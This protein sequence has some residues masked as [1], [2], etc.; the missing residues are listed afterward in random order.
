MSGVK[1][2]R[3]R[4]VVENTGS[5]VLNVEINLSMTN[6]G[7]NAFRCIARTVGRRWMETWNR[8]AEV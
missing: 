3:R 6:G 1:V 2:G 7:K 8:R 4:S 5:S